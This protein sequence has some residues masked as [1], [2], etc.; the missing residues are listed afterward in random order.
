VLGERQAPDKLCASFSR[1]WPSLLPRGNT[2]RRARRRR[3]IM[4]GLASDTN[5]CKIRTTLEDFSAM[6]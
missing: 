3:N 4:L 1:V 2:G 6:M 5:M